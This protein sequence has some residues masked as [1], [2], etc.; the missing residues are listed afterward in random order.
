MNP[1]DVR[2]SL[3]RHATSKI[4]QA[5]DL[6]NIQ[7]Y[8]FGEALPSISSVARFTLRTRQE[9]STEGT[10]PLVNGGRFIHQK[11]CGMP[12]WNHY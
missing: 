8:G 6:N 5:D 3:E 11:S 12:P 10:V 9:H 2:L 1:D 7:S 4:T